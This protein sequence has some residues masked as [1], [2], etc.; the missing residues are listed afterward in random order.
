MRFYLDNSEYE[1]TLDEPR[2]IDHGKV[3][4]EIFTSDARILEINS[5]SDLYPL[6]MAYGIYR[7]RLKDSTIS[8]DTL[9]EQQ[10]VWDKVVAENIFVVCK[11][12]MAKNIT[13]RTLVGFRGTKTNMYAPDDLINKIKNQPELFIKKVYDLVRKRDEI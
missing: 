10:A 12:P 3:T 8:T 5:K 13:K 1:H 4:E 11:T 9:E 6:Y 2:F 7:A